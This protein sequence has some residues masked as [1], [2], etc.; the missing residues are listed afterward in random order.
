MVGSGNDFEVSVLADYRHLT[1]MYDAQCT[2]PVGKQHP[3][4][5]ADRECPGRPSGLP[6][7]TRIGVLA[8]GHVVLIYML[9]AW[10]VPST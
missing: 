4:H 8:V 3:E 5:R 6:A 2:T 7:L 9:N 1:V 10:G